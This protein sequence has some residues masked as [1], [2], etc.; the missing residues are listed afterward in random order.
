M[1]C[2]SD[3]HIESNQAKNRSAEPIDHMTNQKASG[4][5]AQPRHT[6]A[7]AKY[8]YKIYN[9]EILAIIKSFN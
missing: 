6:I 7:L 2:N 3:Y 4:D 5:W 1:C 8:N 9:K